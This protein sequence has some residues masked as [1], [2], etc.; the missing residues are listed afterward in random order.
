M[1]G[2]N[3]LFYLF[4]FITISCANQSKDKEHQISIK[5]DK[6]KNGVEL[7]ILG[8]IQDAGSPHIA[9]TKSCC[10]NLSLEKKEKRKV[11]CLGLID[12]NNKKRYLIEASP[13]LSAQL[14]ELNQ[15]SNYESEKPVDAIF[16]THA[17]IG[18]YSGLMYLG[19]EANDAKEIPVYAM[20]RMKAFL[21]SNGPWDQLVKRKNIAIQEL[22]NDSVIQLS[23]ELSIS[24]FLVPH[25]DEYSETVGY[26]IEGPAKKALFIP[27]IDKWQK[28][29]R[30]IVEEIKKVDYAFVDATFF[31]GAEIG[32]RDISQIPYPFMIESMDLF[33]K[34]SESEKAKIHFIHFNHTN[35]VL[36][37]ESEEYQQVINNGFSVSQYLQKVEL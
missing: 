29:E 28:W 35:P 4:A 18:H 34:L 7:I 31:S 17:H 13:D 8:N 33:S 15:N 30:N 22:K 10:Q 27:D 12:H 24:P 14:D 21:E 5:S 32:H 1:N 23:P 25:R 9:C 19:K 36:N 11:V 3:W 37:P 16:L 2:K 26:L 20:P 6:Q